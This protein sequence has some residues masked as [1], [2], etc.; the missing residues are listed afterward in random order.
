MALP[1]KQ[2]IAAAAS[3]NG[4]YIGC[5]DEEGTLVFVDTITRRSSGPLR[6]GHGYPWWLALSPDGKLAATG[7]RDLVVRLWGVEEGRMLAAWKI[8]RQMIN[9]AFSPDG[10]H[11]A[12]VDNTGRLEVRDLKTEATP[13]R[14]ITSSGILQ[15][16]AFHPVEPRLFL[17]GSDGVVHVIDTKHWQ[18][19]TQLR[20]R[21][22][23]RKPGTIARAA[24]SSDGSVLAAYT[25]T[26][27][28]RLWRRHPFP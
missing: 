14:I 22:D 17:G 18:E 8:N 26:G 21:D 12:L 23:A 10:H 6:T 3:G 7:G 5:V 19:T 13:V 1:I 28:I 11:L 4:P 25:E 20:E 16:I 24:I 15:A 27:T 2:A 9:G